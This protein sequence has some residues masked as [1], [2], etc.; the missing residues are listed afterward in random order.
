MYVS[1][2]PSDTPFGCFSPK[3]SKPASAIGNFSPNLLN[4][5]PEKS[6]QTTGLVSKGGQTVS[7]NLLNL[8]L[9]A[10]SL[11]FSILR[12]F[13]PSFIWNLLVCAGLRHTPEF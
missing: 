3:F 8:I 9:S 6:Q 12:R 1:C 5:T 11:Y 2:F 7:D 4:E 13:V 10:L